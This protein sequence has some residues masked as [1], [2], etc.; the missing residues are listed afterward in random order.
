MSWQQRMIAPD[1]V[2]MCVCVC[3]CVCVFDSFLVH[4]VHGQVRV[5]GRE[6]IVASKTDTY[7][8]YKIE[9]KVSCVLAMEE[10]GEAKCATKEQRVK[11]RA[12]LLDATY[13]YTQPCLFLVRAVCS[14]KAS[15]FQF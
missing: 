13:M 14:P 7:I 12:E 8:S 3:V 2:C 4:V 10:N 15:V 5:V 1:Y 9:T 11:R 6:K